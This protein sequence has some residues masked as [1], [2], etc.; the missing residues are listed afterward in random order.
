MAFKELQSLDF[1]IVISLG[2][3]DKKTG[4]P[5]RQQIEGYYLG[6]KSVEDKKKKSGKSYI[7]GFSTPTGSVG[8]W[9]KTDLDKKMSNAI[10]G[11]M[12]RVTATGTRPTPNGEMY[13]YKVEVDADNTIAVEL[14]SAT[15]DEAF[16]ALGEE[17]AEESD[18]NA[19]SNGFDPDAEDAAQTRALTA[20]EL[21]AKVDA[22]LKGRGGKAASRQ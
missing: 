11:A 20:A 12:T 10:V 15:D 9:G 1:D 17:D 21:K 8:V 13:T 22:R 5:N 14:V 4:K 7:Y 6:S 3:Q 16:E 2:G 19:Y 18:G